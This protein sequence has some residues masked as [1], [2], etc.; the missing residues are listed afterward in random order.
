MID[1]D[2]YEVLNVHPRAHQLVIQA[3]YR[4]LASL[5]HPDRDASDASTHRMAELNIAYAKVRTLDRRQVYD[6]E[7]ERRQQPPVAVVTPYQPSPAAGSDGGEPG[8]LDFGRYNG[9]TIRR[10]ALE[11]PDYLRWL[12]RHSSGIRYRREIEVALRESAGPL[13]SE[14]I[15]G[16]R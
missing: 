14:R 11:D 3:A 13:P 1:R 5:Y 16:R 15:R 7:R 4:V 12:S 10:L 8:I 2:A 6:R 9:W